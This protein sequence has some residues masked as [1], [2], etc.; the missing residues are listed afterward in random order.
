M[1]TDKFKGYE[2]EGVR[3]TLY[4]NGFSNTNIAIVNSK[5]GTAT[6]SKVG[7]DGS[8]WSRYRLV[9]RDKMEL[10]QDISYWTNGDSAIKA[11]IDSIQP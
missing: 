11:G 5:L 7:S 6:V 10:A 3:V 8:K 1:I 2:Q 4:T 9:V